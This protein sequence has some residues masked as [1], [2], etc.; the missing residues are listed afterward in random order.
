M[1]RV[2]IESD[3]ETRVIDLSTEEQKAYEFVWNMPIDHVENC[4][5]ERV[6]K[7]VDQIVKEQSDKNPKKVSDENKLAIVKNANIES[8][9]A[10][11]DRLEVEN[12]G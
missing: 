6:R 10:V 1:C 12:G 8:A 11:N 2:T 9:E 4:V 3:D 7:A 5:R